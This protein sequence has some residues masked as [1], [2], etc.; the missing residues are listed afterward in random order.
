MP[1]Q[2]SQTIVQQA[3]KLL[4]SITLLET[5]AAER[6]VKVKELLA[7]LATH[8]MSAEQLAG[9][10]DVSVESVQKVLD[11][12]APKPPHERV[13]LSEESIEELDPLKDRSAHT[14]TG[15]SELQTG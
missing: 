8:G 5:V 11:R 13:G 4:E 14:D 3:R 6:E 15:A 2:D 1:V 7:F 10:L 9:N 12:D